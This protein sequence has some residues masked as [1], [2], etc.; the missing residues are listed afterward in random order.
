MR[1]LEIARK[2]AAK[3]THRQHRHGAVVVRGG[4]VLAAAA[5]SGRRG[6]CAERRALQ[7]GTFHGA[8]VYTARSNRL[9][10]KPCDDCIAAMKAAGVRLVV[11]VDHSGAVVD[12]LLV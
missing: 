1:Y 7:R 4:A 11:Y 12:E 6:R 3:S 10:S 2:V 5:N 9:C 8:T